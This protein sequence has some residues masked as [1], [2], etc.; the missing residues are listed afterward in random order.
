LL[1]QYQIEAADSPI[2]R[3]ERKAWSAY[4]FHSP[5][6]TTTYFC[7]ASTACSMTPRVACADDVIRINVSATAL[8]PQ[9]HRQRPALKPQHAF[10][11]M[12][13]DWTQRQV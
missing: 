1:F 2:K 5:I 10:L 13:K 4:G 6:G 8:A 7:C 12:A 9:Q 3:R 11:G